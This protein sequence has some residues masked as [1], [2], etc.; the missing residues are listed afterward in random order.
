M[1]VYTSDM[2]RRLRNCF[3]VLC[4]LTP[5]FGAQAEDVAC[6][7]PA[8]RGAA[9]SALSSQ[10]KL[11]ALVI[12]A[13]FLD[14][15]GSSTAPAFAADLFSPEL[16]GSLTHFFDEMSAGQFSFTGEVL[17]KV[18][19]SVNPTARY[20]SSSESGRGD[21]GRFTR[22]ILDAADADVDFGR[23]DN[24]GADGIPNS[25][26]DDGFVDL[27]L[28]VTQ[29]TPSGF[30]VGDADGVALLG[31]DLQ[32]TT[33]DNA[34]GGRRIA[35]RQDAANAPGGALQRGLSFTDAVGIIAH[36]MGHILGLPDLYDRANM[37]AGNID[38]DED[39]AGIGYWG[40]MGHGARGWDDRGG[41][42]P[43]CAWSRK[44]LGW[45]GVG[46]ERLVV[47]TN[48]VEDAFLGDS[49]DGGIVYQIPLPDSE[50]LLVEHRGAANS[51]YERHLPAEGVLVWQ[52]N[53]DQPN[54]DREAAKLVDLV[55][56]DGLFTD[57]GFP[58]GASADVDQGQDNL[59]FHSSD[60]AYRTAHEGNLGDATDVF[61]GVR[62][63]EYAPLSNPAINGVSVNNIR[64]AGSGFA[65]DLIL[66]DSRRAGMLTGRQTWR[67]TMHIIGDVTIA[68]GASVD[69]APGTVVSIGADGRHQGVDADRV[70]ITVDGTLSSSGATSL[71][72]S[73]ASAPAPGD[74]VGITATRSGLLALGSMT[75]EH[76]RDAVVVRGGTRGLSMRGVTVRST[77]NDGIR[78]LSV[79]G[80]VLLLRVTVEGV[81]GTALFMEGGDAVTAED[82]QL[83]N[84]GGHGLVRI[85]GRLRLDN[86]EISGN[87]RSPE[88]ST[89][90]SA[91]GFDLWMQEG[92]G[93]TI[94]GTRMSGT[95]EGARV[96]LTGALTLTQNEWTGYRVALR[97]ISANPVVKANV[98]DEVDTVLSVQ[99]F[100]VP[101]TLLLNIV[102]DP[103]V[104]IVNDT[105]QRLDAGRNWW[106][107]TEV[108]EISSGMRGPV[109]WDP[110]LNF[111]PRLP[112]DFEL[113]QN[114][115]NPFNNSTVI[116]FSV[117]LLNASLVAGELM[118]LDV[119]TITGG[120]VRRL[121]EQAAAPGIYR[122]VWDGRDESGAAVASGV[123]YYELV[124]GR[125]RL[126]RRLTVL[127]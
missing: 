91:R 22:E 7:G 1:E 84:S 70:E 10:G 41:P 90:G 9:V 54:N 24:D 98:F 15:T 29:S 102:N 124:V 116:N 47:L 120:R 63:T 12:F 104:L 80:S 18:Y 115:P 30:I 59:D 88:G 13:R 72:T 111:D 3:V 66:G 103:Q 33:S 110:A 36:E 55:A 25:G 26:D 14:E 77:A 71:F 123:Y 46:N 101:S 6:A 100:R 99:G 109:D 21:F 40:L 60:E 52:V 126:L 89:A 106:G 85:D 125:L 69:I 42:T 86:S 67:D 81:G 113:E 37:R 75:I 34:A 2:I 76:A 96:E 105:E 78:L 122:S 48:S 95:G 127:R 61:D 119:Y 93:G 117:S 50:Y 8:F 5:I 74:W 45:L 65:A 44:Q 112:V 83:R 23:F 87:G 73:A 43:F 39:S 16:P 114:F 31:L 49:N 68:S 32:Y 27:L 58:L 56:A 28:L 79:E 11:H 17:P 82:L 64:R 97:T 38:L 92:S 107:T 108:A 62:F 118:S 19:S 51:H 53:P 94:S 35:V 4:G 20:L 121:L 57:A